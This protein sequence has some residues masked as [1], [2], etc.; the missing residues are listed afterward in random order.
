M[1][2]IFSKFLPLAFVIVFAISILVSWLTDAQTV[3]TDSNVQTNS[4]AAPLRPPVIDDFV[5]EFRDL[6]TFDEMAATKENSGRVARKLID[7]SEFKSPDETWPSYSRT[8]L[9][10]KSGENWLGLYESGGKVSLAET[11]VRRSPRHGYI[12]PGD[13]LYDW[14]HYERKGQLLFI[15][16][17]IGEL[18]PSNVATIFLRTR[19]K[20]SETESL[21]VGYRRIFNFAGREYVL[22][23]TTGIQRDDERVNVLV[24]ESGGTSQIV[25]VNRYYKD[26]Y[27]LY[28]S[29]GELL[30]VGDMDGD[31]K[32]DLYFSDFG[33]EKGGFGSNL[34]LSSPAKDGNLVERVAG[35][36]SAGC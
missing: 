20:N 21:D 18:K 27:T 19:T 5:P 14:L 16:K 4:N 15:V 30:W 36:N 34:Y 31:G 28:N 29:I 13:E 22:R 7:I 3:R 33:F 32:L 24:L 23:V 9:E 35:F 11:K 10:A 12:G 1:N 8:E 26:Q 2:Q 6:P 17:G 25:T